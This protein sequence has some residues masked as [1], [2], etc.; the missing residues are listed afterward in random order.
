MPASEK[1]L[2]AWIERHIKDVAGNP[3][4]SANRYV[5]EATCLEIARMA[6]SAGGDE[7][8]VSREE[9]HLILDLGAEMGLECS[10]PDT[11][12]IL[13]AAKQEIRQL[14]AEKKNV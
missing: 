4:G 6:Y 11:A 9:L 8:A 12:F 13:Q 1:Y 3:A 10:L 2:P 14:R 5:T 7:H